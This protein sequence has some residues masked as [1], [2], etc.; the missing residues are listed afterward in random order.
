MT[1][2]GVVTPRPCIGCGGSGRSGRQ[3]CRVCEGHGSL[4]TLE[5]APAPTTPTTNKRLGA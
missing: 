1:E 5:L 2:R 4:L 3:P